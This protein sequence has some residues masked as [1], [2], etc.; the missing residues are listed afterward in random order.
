MANASYTYTVPGSF[1]NGKVAPARLDKEIRESAIVT[2]LDGVSTGGT[3]CTVTFKAQLSSTDKQ[4]LD[5]DPSQTPNPATPCPVGSLIGDHS[6][7]PLSE[8][9][10]IPVQPVDT[11]GLDPET[12]LNC[13]EGLYVPVEIGVNPSVLNQTWPFPIDAVAARYVFDNPEWELGDKFDAFGIGAGDPSVGPV[14][15]PVAQG[16]RVIPVY[17]TVF[18]YVRH[19][20]FVKFGNEDKEYRVASEDQQ[21]GTITIMEDLEVALS[22][23]EDVRLRRPFAISVPVHKGVLYPI[24]DLTAGSSLVSAGNVLRIRYHHKTAPPSA[25]EIGMALITLF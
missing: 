17:P 25:Y 8:Q 20:L 6:G 23:G 5:G 14:T 24:G 13:T 18:Q 21:A 11:S 22:G 19:G 3:T 1:P 10:P 4:I 7:E 16:G 2:A 15:A 12:A 9:V